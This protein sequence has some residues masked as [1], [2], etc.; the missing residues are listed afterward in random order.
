VFEKIEDA[1]TVHRLTGAC[2]TVALHIPWDLPP[3]GWTGPG[4][5][6]SPA[7]R[8]YSSAR[9]TRTCSRS[10]STCSARCATPIPRSGAARSPT[11]GVRR[12]RRRG[13][14]A[15]RLDLA[16]RRDQLPGSG[17][18]Q[19]PA[20]AAERGARAGLRRAAGGRRDA[21]R[22]QAVRARLLHHRPAGLGDRIHDLPPPR[23]AG[24]GAGGHRHT[25]RVPTSSSSSLPCSTRGAS[26]GSTSTTAATPTTT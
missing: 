14:R 15:V 18:H 13:R 12:D 21:G 10:T 22:V 23:A 20:G 8:G 25:R 3:A 24:Q 7:N 17:R 26:A 6:A 1:A 4:S 11:P 9:S 19:G 2:P 16:R 5:P